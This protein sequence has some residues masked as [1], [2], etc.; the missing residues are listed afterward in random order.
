MSAE[1]AEI[2]LPGAQRALDALEKLQEGFFISRHSGKQVVEWTDPKNGPDR[3]SMNDAAAHYIKVLRNSTHGHG[4]KR[5]DQVARTNA[6][7]V[8]HD[9]HVPHDLALLGYLYL[10]D[11]LSRTDLLALSLYQNGK[12]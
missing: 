12:V 6:L 8:H 1:A 4:S 10:L 5:R 11:I 2:L 3:L 9:G 7:L